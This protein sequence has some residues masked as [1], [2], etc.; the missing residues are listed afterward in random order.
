MNDFV[1]GLIEDR[2]DLVRKS[3]KGEYH[4]HGGLGLR[5][6]KFNELV[7]GKAKK[8]LLPMN[9]LEGLDEYI[10]GE[11][12]PHLSSGGEEIVFLW[13]EMIK[14]AVRDGI[15][16]IEPS[17][18]CH[19]S[20]SFGGTEIMVEEIRKLKKKYEGQIEFRPE[21]GIAKSCGESIERYLVPAIDSGV[22]NS[23]DLYGQEFL[24]NFEEFREVYSYAG[25]K[26]IKLKAHAGE[27]CGSGNVRKAMEILGIDEIQHGIGA[28]EDEYVI[29]MIRERGIRLNVCPTSNILLGAVKD[30]KSHPI[31][32]LFQKGI[33]LSVNSDDLLIFDK[34]VS[35][36][37]MY[38]YKSGLFSAEELDRIR[39]STLD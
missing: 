3:P 22:Y 17:M 29:D 20:I 28:V 14:E 15:K 33:K 36:E 9:G 8:P 24:D 13:E 11:L 16:I 2:L 4:N 5:F 35:E 12:V 10:F 34:G 25:K 18:D 27:F 19:E 39:L 6:D 38:L 32:K 21:V 1:K 37:Y 31:K 7:K 26:G 30:I 23:I